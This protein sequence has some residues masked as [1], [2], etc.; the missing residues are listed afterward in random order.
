MSD[1]QDRCARFRGLPDNSGN[2]GGI[3]NE[4]L[5]DSPPMHYSIPTSPSI[6][7]AIT[8]NADNFNKLLDALSRISKFETLDLGVIR[9]IVRRARAHGIRDIAAFLIDHMSF[10]A[11]AVNDIALYLDSITDLEFVA[12]H[13]TRLCNLR[14]QPA[15]NLRAVRLWLEWYFS[16]HAEL[17]CIPAIREFVSGSRRLRPQARAAITTKNQAWIKEM[18]NQ[19][20]HKAFWDRRSIILAAQI[21]SKDE[22]THWLRPLMKGS[23]LDQM[24][25][26]MAQWVLDGAS[27]QRDVSVEC[28]DASPLIEGD[29]IPF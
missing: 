17:L 10:F 15:A 26:W 19:L 20:L 2:I 7:I 14:D 22:R 24:D 18:K 25:T 12:E 29:D 28:N 3:G 6:D 9:A 4:Y 23:S 5:V 27:E 1:E 11:P 13:G 8:H 21:L 16:R